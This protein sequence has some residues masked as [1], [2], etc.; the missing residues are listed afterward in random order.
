MPIECGES[1]LVANVTSPR[2]LISCGWLQLGQKFPLP[3][4]GKLSKQLTKDERFAISSSQEVT[5][6]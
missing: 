3:V 5:L 1:L 2:A 4:A 6:K